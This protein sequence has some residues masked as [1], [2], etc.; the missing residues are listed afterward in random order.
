MMAS[1]IGF[2]GR[3]ASLRK[4][5]QG[6]GLRWRQSKMNMQILIAKHDAT[7]KRRDLVV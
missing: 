4:I 6:L 5:L 3:Q 1:F 7:E 2:T